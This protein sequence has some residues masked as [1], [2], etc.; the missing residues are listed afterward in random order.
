MED[1][2]LSVWRLLPSESIIYHF[3]LGISNRASHRPRHRHCSPS[4]YCGRTRTDM[5]VNVLAL[6]RLHPSGTCCLLTSNCTSC[7]HNCI[8]DGQCTELKSRVKSQTKHW[9]G[10]SYNLQS[11]VS[12]EVQ[13][14]PLTQRGVTNWN[15]LR[16]CLWLQLRNV[17]GNHTCKKSVS[18]LSMLCFCGCPWKGPLR[19]LTEGHKNMTTSGVSLSLLCLVFSFIELYWVVNFLWFGFVSML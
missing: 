14:F 17:C 18:N 13:I 6:L 9:H 15:W 11:P 4:A 8:I 10:Y 3:D 16:K 1:K 12:S 19:F 5:S 7:R 2:P